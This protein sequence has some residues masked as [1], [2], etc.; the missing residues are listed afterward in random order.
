MGHGIPS[1]VFEQI[2]QKFE[3]INPQLKVNASTG[4][5]LP[6]SQMVVEAHGDH[7]WVESE[8]GQGTSFYF[9]IPLRKQN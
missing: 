1:D 8:L 5:G 3:Q 7:I 9:T 4:L 6:F 2:F